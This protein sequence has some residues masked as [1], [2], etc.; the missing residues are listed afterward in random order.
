MAVTATIANVQKDS[1]G[2]RVFYR[3]N[4]GDDRSQLFPEDISRDQIISVIRREV[5]AKNDLER[6]V[7]SFRDLIG[8]EIG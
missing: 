8:Q 6:T 5:S 2:I 7:E 3:F 1:N 4:D